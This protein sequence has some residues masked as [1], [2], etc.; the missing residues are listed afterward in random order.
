MKI[1]EAI[2]DEKLFRPYL[3]DND[4]SLATWKPWFTFLQVLYGLPVPRKAHDLIREC[5]GRDPALL[6][7]QGFDRALLLTG[8]RCGKS[9]T[10]ALVGAHEAVFAGHEKK[11]SR[12]EQGLVG[13]FSPTRRQ[14]QVIKGYLRSVFE[15]DLLHREIT[16]ETDA[17]FTLRNGNKI[18]II[19][20]D[21]RSV[22]GFT[23]IAAIVDEAAFF[24][25]D[26]DTNVKTDA[27]LIT[28]IEPGLMTTG[29]R[30]LVISTP[31]WKKG[32]CWETYSTEW[33]NDDSDTLVFNAATCVMNAKITQA[34]VDRAL[35]R[36]YA[37]NIAEYLGRFRDDVGM[38]I[39]RA[40]VEKVVPKGRTHIP[41][42]PD[43][44]YCGFCDVSGGRGDDAALAIAHKEGD[45]VVLDLL[46]T[47]PAPFNPAQLVKEMVQDLRRYR[48]NKV[49]GDNYGAA[50]VSQSFQ[51][52]RVAY[53]KSKLNKA[54]LYIELLPRLTSEQV[55]LLDSEVLI[56]QL[57]TLERKTRAGGRD[58]VDHQKNM[59]DDAANAVAG[60]VQIFAAKRHVG[61]VR[62][63]YAK[64]GGFSYE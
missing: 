61:A 16:G 21:H 57:C 55:E 24:G 12:G 64:Q 17:G 43:T 7:R 54:E 39:S 14:S 49:T 46:R 6:P 22:R 42:R 58:I 20:G 41:W 34:E 9:K 31:Y 19:T 45:K 52:H 30:L 60:V 36:D 13:I 5:T 25:V 32:W 48:I 28:A 10:S 40:L 4:G 37:K 26:A 38:F 33:A 62:S 63:R 23:L 35:K 29:G 53:A 2:H 44:E 18:E 11:L 15:T 3:A 47:W 27:E 8:R 59:K 50:W 56:N 51:P 1:L